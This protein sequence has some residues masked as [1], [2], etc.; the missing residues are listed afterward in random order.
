MGVSGLGVTVSVWPCLCGL[1]FMA[2]EW[3]HLAADVM[4]MGEIL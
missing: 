4:E 2:A 3:G 1:C